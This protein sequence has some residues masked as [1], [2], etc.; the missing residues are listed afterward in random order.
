MFT[1]VDNAA[2]APV[3]AEAE[4]RLRRVIEAVGGKETV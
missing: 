1:M 3:A 2:V 4:E